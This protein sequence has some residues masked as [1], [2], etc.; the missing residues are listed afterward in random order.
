MSDITDNLKAA[1]PMVATALGGPLAGLAAEWVTSKLGLPPSTPGDVKAILSGLSSDKLEE[2]KRVEFEF[3]FKIA[4][5]GYDS[6]EK[7]ES[8]N[9]QIVQA[10]NTTMQAESKSE[11]W[12]QWFWRPYIGLCF[13]TQVF[14]TYFILPILEVPVPTIPE[15]VWVAYGA[16]LGVTAWHRGRKQVV[17]AETEKDIGA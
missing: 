5:L 11:H 1:I 12:A 8:L 3:R 2:L 15:T 4:Q 14:G 17:Q 10:V 6:L 16:V 9:V 7:V 13:G